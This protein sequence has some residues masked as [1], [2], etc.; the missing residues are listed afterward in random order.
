MDTLL[1]EEQQLPRT[2]TSSGMDSSQHERLALLQSGYS[3]GLTSPQTAEHQVPVSNFEGNVLPWPGTSI[4]GQDN[5]PQPGFDTTGQVAPPGMEPRVTAT[6]WEDEASL[7]FQV[8]A[9]GVCVARR[10]G[11]VLSLG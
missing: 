10:E 5:P 3:N 1:A 4:P 6:L 11:N 7:C 8:E 9:R 2:V